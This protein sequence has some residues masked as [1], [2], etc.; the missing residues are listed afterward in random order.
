MKRITLFI[1]IALIALLSCE[2]EEPMIMLTADA[3]PPEITGLPAGFTKFITQETLND[4]LELNWSKADYGVS[5]E[6]KY[7]VEMDSKCNSFATPVVIG[8]TT[9]TALSITLDNLNAKLLGELEVASHQASELQLRVTATMSN[10]FLEVSD[11][12]PITIKPWNDKPAALYAGENSSS[13]PV[14]YAVSKDV[15]EGYKYLVGGS[16][17]RFSDNTLCADSIFGSSGVPGELSLTSASTKIAIAESGYYKVKVDRKNLHYEITPANWGMIGTATPGGWN[18][19]T[20]L[21]YNADKDVWEGQLDLAAGALK[22]RANNG[23]D[24]N[25]GPAASNDLSGKLIETNDAITISEPGNYKV[26]VDFSQSKS[27]YVYQYT[28]VR[29]GD[30]TEPAKLW[31]PGGYQGWNPSTAPTIYAISDFVYV[32]YVYINAGTAFKF[33]NAPDWDHINYG[34][35]GT[36]G[37]LTTDGLANG[38]SL[39]VPG[40]YR[41]KADTENLAYETALIDSWGMIGTAT[42][43]GWDNSSPMIYDQAKDVW[44]A[45]INLVPGALKFRANNKWDI[46]YGPASSAAMNG[47]LIETNDSISIQEAGNYT[48]TI[49]LSRSKA[50][51][52]FIYTVVKN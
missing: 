9:S 46:N 24:I 30:V 8:T 16:S 5:T 1:Y 31:L 35:S 26:T 37:V 13:A 21:T 44:K 20:P 7:T 12:I 22:F 43:G 40:Y 6:V 17:F 11:G 10:R 28:V 36:K 2:K 33:T 18:N 4:K 45:T 49:D 19:S 32:G 34:D 3:K 14:L 52:Q 15:F 38:L 29:S 27:P 48:V 50:P 42:P 39:D 25:Y 47:T 23:W 51:Y 41:L